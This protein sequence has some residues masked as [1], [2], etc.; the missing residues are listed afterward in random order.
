MASAALLPELFGGS[1]DLTGSNNTWAKGSRRITRGDAPAT[2]LHYG[3][4]EFGMTAM[5]NGIA[6]H[7]GFIP[8]GGTFLVFSDYARNAV[9]MAALMAPRVDL[10]LHARLHRPGRGRPDPSA[11]RAPAARC[12]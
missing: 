3:V 2:T 10:R 4:R 9:R 6:L 8:Y 11:D 1:A 7:G 5:M 12:G